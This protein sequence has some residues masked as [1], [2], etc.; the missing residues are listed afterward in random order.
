RGRGF[1]PPRRQEP[2]ER[3]LR[4]RS[5]GG[6]RGRGGVDAALGGRQEEDA[7]RGGPHARHQRVAAQGAGDA[8]DQVLDQPDRALRRRRADGRLGPDR[9]EDHRRHLRRGGAAPRRRGFPPRP[10]PRPPPRGAPRPPP[11]PKHNGPRAGRRARARGVAE[12]MSRLV[13]TSGTGTIADEKISRAV[14]QTFDCRPGMI[15]RE[16]DLLKPIY[17]PTAAYGHFGRSEFRWEQTDRAEALA[18]A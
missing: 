14:R 7:R 5:P 9:A 15:I 6:D 11:R 8:Q 12:P 4:E 2:G 18:D 13:N 16:L 17:R 10:P 1:A 3:P